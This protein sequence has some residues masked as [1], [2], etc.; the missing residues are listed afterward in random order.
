MKYI[1]HVLDLWPLDW[2]RAHRIRRFEIAYV[3]E[4]HA[5]DQLS[6]Y[7]E[8]AEE[9]DAFCIRIV[10]TSSETADPVE[11]CRSKVM[12]SRFQD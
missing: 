11:V 8:A 2:Y 1:E 9:P 7:R 5:G 4:A 10:K 12:F 6:F 3:A